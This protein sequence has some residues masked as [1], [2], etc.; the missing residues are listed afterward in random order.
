MNCLGP[1]VKNQLTVNVIIYFW[2]LNPTLLILLLTLVLG[3]Y[4]LHC[5]SLQ[6]VLKPQSP[7]SP[8]LSFYG[9]IVLTLLDASNVHM[10][11]EISSSM[12]TKRIMLFS[13]LQSINMVYYQMDFQMLNQSCIPR[14]KS[15]LAMMYNPFYMLL[16]SVC[17]EDSTQYL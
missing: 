11:F 13:A 8:A 1:L 7:S 14:K 16:V 17:S 2:I 15:H 3:P 12:S 10:N 5:C 6:Q 9:K 4:R